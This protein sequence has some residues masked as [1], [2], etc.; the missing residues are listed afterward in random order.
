MDTDM[1]DTEYGHGHGKHGMIQC[2]VFII[3]TIQRTL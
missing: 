3:I 2:V 1:G